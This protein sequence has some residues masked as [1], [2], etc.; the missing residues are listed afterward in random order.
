M[1]DIDACEINAYMENVCGAGAIELQKTESG[2]RVTYE[3]TR[4]TMD[5]DA[6]P[7]LLHDMIVQLTLI[8]AKIECVRKR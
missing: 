3:S 1:K 2:I 6:D 4:G 8:K 5:I 7:W